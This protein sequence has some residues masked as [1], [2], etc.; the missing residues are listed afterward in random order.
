LLLNGRLNNLSQQL[1]LIDFCKLLGTLLEKTT[2]TKIEVIMQ[3]LKM[4]KKGNNKLII[5]TV[6]QLVIL[7]IKVNNYSGKITQFKEF[8]KIKQNNNMLISY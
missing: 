8:E 1:R 5:V 7:K 4:T 2:L 6:L 3:H